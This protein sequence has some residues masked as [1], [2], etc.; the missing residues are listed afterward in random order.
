VAN[1]ET[2]P[3]LAPRLSAQTDV[4]SALR[5][6]YLQKLKEVGLDLPFAD[7]RPAQPPSPMASG[8][9]DPK[10]AAD[11]TKYLE[12]MRGYTSWPT[13]G[14]EPRVNFMARLANV[15]KQSLPYLGSRL[16]HFQDVLNQ[17]MLEVRVWLYEQKVQLPCELFAGLFPTGQLN[18]RAIP[19][20]GV[21]ALL[22]VNVGLMDLIFMLLKTNIATRAKNETVPLLTDE[23]AEMVLADVFNAYLYGEGS[24]GAWSL[25]PLPQEREGNLAFVL[26]RAEQ[27]VLAHEIGHVVLGHVSID[28]PEKRHRVGDYTQEQENEA[29]QF[30]LE[31][32]LRAHKQEPQWELRSSFL[33][34]AV[35]TF[36]AVADAVQRLQQALAQ[37]NAQTESHPALADRMNRAAQQLRTALPIP[38]LLARA[39]IFADWLNTSLCAVTDWLALVKETMNRPTPWD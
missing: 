15:K 28:G 22:L 1:D 32:L 25:P 9:F 3:R 37:S 14:T 26:Q 27:F 23:Q 19:V 12:S 6:S 2:S 29:D 34:G 7:I 11:L 36:F 35:M 20:A 18:A 21:G 17:Q 16:P 38:D 31:L 10:V 24:L 5:D 4:Q 39:E 30:A 8:R 33:A 13:V